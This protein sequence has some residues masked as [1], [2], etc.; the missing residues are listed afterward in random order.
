M[1]GTRFLFKISRREMFY[2]LT[3]NQVKQVYEI[4]DS[5]GLIVIVIA[6]R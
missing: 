4:Q 2:N 6:A 5:K 1:K 3:T